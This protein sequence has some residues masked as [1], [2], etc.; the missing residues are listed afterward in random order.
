LAD[1]REQDRRRSKKVRPPQLADPIRAG[2]KCGRTSAPR[3]PQALHTNLALLWQILAI[4]WRNWIPESDF[5]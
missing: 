4:D 3:L 2:S 1:S 5:Q